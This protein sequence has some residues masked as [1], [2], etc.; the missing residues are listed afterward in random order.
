MTTPFSHPAAQ[1]M[2]AEH[3][4]LAELVE[5]LDHEPDLRELRRELAELTPLLAEHF[6]S[7]E[8]TDGVFRWVETEA[9]HCAHDT[10]TLGDE[11]V[12][13]LARLSRIE[14]RLDELLEG[15][16]AAVERDVAAFV[17]DLRSHEKAETE[18]VANA[19]W[20]D[21]GGGA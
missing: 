11:H 8:A 19:L 18:L 3:E 21:I 9:P 2:E 6:A 12:A 1:R 4:R 10:Q 14:G 17:A 13:L 7:E 5:R 16:V 20:T 15:P